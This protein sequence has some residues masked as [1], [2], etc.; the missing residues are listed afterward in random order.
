[1]LICIF[2]FENVR[3]LNYHVRIIQLV[4]NTCPP[5]FFATLNILSWQQH[6]NKTYRHRCRKNYP[7][8]CFRFGDIFF[9]CC[10]YISCSHAWII[11][12]YVWMA[13][14]HSEEVSHMENI[15]KRKSVVSQCGKLISSFIVAIHLCPKYMV[16][17]RWLR[18]W[19]NG[20]AALSYR[21]TNIYNGK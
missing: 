12:I 8:S 1:M 5:P 15:E 7:A 11:Q 17:V 21:L 19:F 10:V 4:P 6:K 14:N 13:Y 2:S 18:R 20:R 9:I 3:I 16:C